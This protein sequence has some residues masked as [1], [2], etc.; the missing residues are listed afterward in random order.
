MTRR[1]GI[2]FLSLLW[3]SVPQIQAQKKSPDQNAA[4][5]LRN[6]TIDDFFQ[7]KRVADPQLS[8]E[9]DR[10]AYTV[11][12]ANLKDDK[13]QTQV[14]MSPTAGG[15]A[16]PMTAK[17]SSASRP[18]WSPDGKFL[19]FLAARNDDKTQVWTLNRQGGDSQQLTE[20]RQGVQA[21]EW[22]PDGQRLVLVIQDPTPEEKEAAEKNGKESKPKKPRPWV[23]D[24]L[25][26]KRDYVGY[27]D[28]RRTHLYVFEVASKKLVQVTSGDF[29][30][31][32]PAWSPDG[33]LLAFVSNRDAEPDASYN[34]DIWVVATDNSDQGRTPL[35]VTTNP[36]PDRSPA[37]SPDGKWIAHLSTTD[38]E[39]MVYA[40][41]HLAVAAAAGG[42][43][44]VLTAKLD[45]HV[46]APRFTRDGK[47]IYFLLEDSA[48]QHLA[49]IPRTGGAVTRPIA[50][51]RS[52]QA[53]V[54]GADDTVA[55]LISDPHLPAEIHL[56]EAGKLRRVTKTNDALLAQLRLARVENIHYRSPDGTEI[57]G[58]LYKPP[59]FT[60]E[61]RH[62]TLLRIHGGPIAQY[63]FRFNFDAQLFAAHGYV[64][65]M[66]NPRG[67]SGYGQ[68][69]SLAIFRGWGIK[70]FEDVMAGV[71][72]AIQQ[73]YADPN[74]LGVGGWS[75]G[76]ILTNYVITKTDRF[77]GAISGASE[78]LMAANYG[79][80]IYQ[81]WW[82]QEFG[83]P[84]EDR[85]IYEKL[86]AFNSVEKIVT[87]TLIMGG[88]EDWNVPIQNSE[89]L[90]QALKRLGRTTQL[91]VYP[92]EYHSIRTPSYQK[93]RFERYL[94]WYARYVKGEEPPAAPAHKE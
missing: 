40:T 80:D 64:V 12:S 5:A 88:E 63:D 1:I 20:I 6:L 15:E 86:S 75:Y 7:L 28:R 23:I 36:G 38:V 43:D 79:H 17:G 89:Q 37:W 56:L 35:Q 31:T 57:E 83:L 34:T 29:D 44:R 27:L 91:V 25:Q 53:F 68:D 48:E 90:Y 76:G 22:S 78:V 9:G 13:W 60:P 59:T 92:G 58:F 73:G 65:V 4:Q 49:R 16:I 61:M 93:D 94:D 54:L 3:L 45:R 84:W 66:T 70:D 46:A 62:P 42:D 77:Q 85:E 19:A 87:P 24:R 71:D 52:V 11:Q 10:V 50:G 39:A 26:F 32:Q 51:A 41:P 69:F 14:W 55:A 81:R 21:Y 72:Y 33:R 67:S 2:L 47:S 30:D 18:R 82:E 8:P 74:R